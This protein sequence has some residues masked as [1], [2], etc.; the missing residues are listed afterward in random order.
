[1]DNKKNSI[2]EKIEKWATIFFFCASVFV[3]ILLA[4]ALILTWLGKFEIPYLLPSVFTS[5][6]LTIFFF[7]FV[8][9]D[10]NTLPRLSIYVLIIV[11]LVSLIGILFPHDTS[12]GRDEGGYSGIAV[13]L[14]KNNNNFL[15]PSNL[16]GAPLILNDQLKPTV[17]SVST[18]SYMVWLAIH[19]IFFGFQ[20]LLRG[21]IPL[22]ILSLCSLYLVSSLFTKKSISLIVVALF[23]SSL[24]F[25]W[26]MRETMSENLS[27]FLL[28]TSMVFFFVFFR[29]KRNV[30]LVGLILGMWLFSFTRLEGI[31]IQLT[32]FLVF[33]SI[34][35]ITRTFPLR[36][37]LLTILIYFVIIVSTSLTSKSFAHNS[38]LNTT[39][40]IVEHVIK[41]SISKPY[42]E[43]IRKEIV[44]ADRIPVFAIQMLAKYNLVLILFSILLIVPLLFL[45]KKRTKEE[46]IFIIGLLI[47]ISPEYYKFIDPSVTLEQP[48][49]YRRYLYALLPMGYLCFSILTYKLLGQKLW[50]VL[51][52]VFIIINIFLSSKIITLKNNWGV[53]E[54]MEKLTKNISSDD[55][56]IVKNWTVLNDYF[57]MSFLTYHKEA[58]TLVREMIVKEE[59]LPQEHKYKGIPY[60]KLF[61]LSDNEDDIFKGFK[62]LKINSVEVDYK[63]L[64]PNCVLYLLNNELGLNIRD[65]YYL[66]YSNVT[67]HC[68][69]TDN[70]ISEI[71]KKIFL[72]EMEYN[73]VPF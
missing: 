69:K 49:M 15:M 44:L 22:T 39:I 47:I 53:K 46:K 41:Q 7:F 11:L 14:S 38:Y 50:T 70:E 35:L 25:L 24:P 8:K 5:L 61:F 48:W 72:Y 56:V 57:P 28:W 43:P 27:L 54:Q 9:K 73:S 71:R 12:G 63:Q 33:S 55:F 4:Q 68:N 45:D 23:S 59:W 3:M 1:M 16:F 36:R 6:I 34:L 67:S 60:N 18:P 21:N 13:M 17:A 31:L 32:T 51:L 10:I 2:I 65:Y 20:W 52:G 64:K 26:F 29:T 37:K 66:P 42:A 62:L 58:G 30:Y 40:P 19:N